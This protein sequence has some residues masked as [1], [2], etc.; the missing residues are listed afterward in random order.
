MHH[1][2]QQP[3]HLIINIIW[4]LCNTVWTAAVWKL[5]LIGWIKCL[6]IEWEVYQ[7]T[8][9]RCDSFS[10]LFLIGLLGGVFVVNKSIIIIIMSTTV[11][12]TFRPTSVTTIMYDY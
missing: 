9:G 10:L 8:D 3:I 5:E 11:T 6:H 12:I 2:E 4:P 1:L 7:I